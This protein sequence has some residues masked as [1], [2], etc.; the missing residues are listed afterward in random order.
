MRRLR[1][2]LLLCSSIALLA[3]Q[4]KELPTALSSSNCETTSLPISV[5]SS[6]TTTFINASEGYRVIFQQDKNGVFEF[7]AGLN[8][9]EEV[10]LESN[11]LRHW[12]I[13]DGPGN[14]LEVLDGSLGD[15][16]SITVKNKNFGPE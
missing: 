12:M 16:V 7:R 2:G 15:R 4:G 5:E 14:C 6:K 1:A 10:M 11:G 3:C 13:T 9:E 8:P